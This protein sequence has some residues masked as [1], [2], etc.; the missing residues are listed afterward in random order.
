MK[1]FLPTAII[2]LNTLTVYGQTSFQKTYGGAG[3][4]FGMSVQ[5]TTD[6]GYILFGQTGSFGGGSQAMYLVKTD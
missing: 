6:G 5:Q 2:I 1:L 3:N 4:D